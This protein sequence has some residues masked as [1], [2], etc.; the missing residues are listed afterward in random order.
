MVS[1]GL[2][3]PHGICI[4]DDNIVSTQWKVTPLHFTPNEQ[5]SYYISLGHLGGHMEILI[6]Q[7]EWTSVAQEMYYIYVI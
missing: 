1:E 3:R 2:S 5:A 4:L 7:L 6:A